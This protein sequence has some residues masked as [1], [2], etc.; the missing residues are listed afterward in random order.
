MS[1]DRVGG[2]VP[3]LPH[4]VGPEWRGA[5]AGFSRLVLDLVLFADPWLLLDLIGGLINLGCGRLR[6]RLASLRLLLENELVLEP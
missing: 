2:A 1:E 3:G 6:G 4:R 5:H